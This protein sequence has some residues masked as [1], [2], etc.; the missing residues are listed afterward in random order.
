[1]AYKEVVG[2]FQKQA[3]EIYKVYIGDEIIEATAE[4]PFWL[5][6]KGW[7]EVK[8]LKVGDLLVTSGGATLAIDNIEKEPREATVYNFEVADFESYFVSNLGIWVHNCALQNVY[9]SIKDSPLYPQGFSGAKNG[10]V[11]NKVNN[12]ELLEELRAVESGTWH[13][14]YK[15]GVDA[16]GNKISIHYFQSQSGQVF[17]VKTKNGWSN[18]SSQM[19]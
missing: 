1:M 10:T 2:L 4:H 3:D 18:S 12:G 5:D 17:N 6:G 16:K 15:D 11:K 8:Y 19:P 14:I 7:T 9:K 13:K